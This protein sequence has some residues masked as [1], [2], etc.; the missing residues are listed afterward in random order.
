MSG[1]HDG[2]PLPSRVMAA[3]MAGGASST[4]FVSA[5]LEAGAMGFVAAGYRSAAELGAQLEEIKA[6][7]AVLGGAPF[8]VNLFVPD[9]APVD[10]QAVRDYAEALRPWADRL[11]VAVPEPVLDDDDDYPAKIRLLLEHPAPVVSF[12]FGLPSAEDAQA[13]QAGGTRLWATV[14]HRAEAEAALA[15][16]VDA[17]VVQH[18]S[19]GGHSGRFLPGEPP[20]TDD[21]A[22]LVAALARH[23]PL[24]LIAAGGIMSPADARA[25]YDAGA[26]AVQLGTALLRTPESGARPVHKDA[27]GD[28]RFVATRMTRAFTGRRARSLENAFL[29][30]Y[31][32]LAPDAYPAI[33][34]LTAPLRAEAARQGLA[35]GVNLWAG[36]GWRQASTAPLQEVLAPFLAAASER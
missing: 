35:D 28:P 3:P 15:L 13:L 17:L 6:R 12:T 5:A 16:G 31:D 8:G 36:T 29:R 11:G 19:A 7:S 23:I 10:P 22:A 32:A 34:H 33:H 30:E 24:P 9:S 21:A 25:A 4:A 26:S 27:L 18:E 20:A 14:T 2:M 1:T